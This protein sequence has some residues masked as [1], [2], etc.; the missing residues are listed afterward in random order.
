MLLVGRY[1]EVLAPSSLRCRA[2]V[3][4]AGDGVLD[5]Q[6]GAVDERR[7]ILRR[8]QSLCSCRSTAAEPRC[9]ASTLSATEESPATTV[10][11]TAGPLAH[12]G[13][14][15]EDVHPNRGHVRLDGKSTPWTWLLKPARCLLVP[16]V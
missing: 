11:W 10:A 7:L 3:V 6:I 8:R 13:D 15:A 16:E 4:R 12:A 1:R 5:H 14:R 2:D 9:A